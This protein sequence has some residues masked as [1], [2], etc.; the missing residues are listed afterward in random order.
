MFTL[1]FVLQI[2]VGALGLEWNALIDQLLLINSQ[3]SLYLYSKQYNSPSMMER[4]G[5]T[6]NPDGSLDKFEAQRTFEQ[7]REDI[8]DFFGIRPRNA[9]VEFTAPQGYGGTLRRI[10]EQRGHSHEVIDLMVRRASEGTEIGGCA[11]YAGDI[12]LDP[13]TNPQYVIFV[14]TAAK[15]AE[16]PAT[17]GEEVTHGEHLCEVISRENITYPQYLLKFHTISNE[18]LG[19][20][21]RKRILELLDQDGTYDTTLDASKPLT[22]NQWGHLFG[23]LVVDDLMEKQ[24]SLPAKDLFLAPDEATMW[25]ILQEAMGEPFVFGLNFAKGVN[26]DGLIQPLNDLIAE[27]KAENYIKLDFRQVE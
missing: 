8:A 5:I 10:L 21:G 24:K 17:L 12:A 6:Y 23:Y 25:K 26:F 18:F 14:S 16:F 27:N 2:E 15:I 7:V 3:V 4:Y 11:L 9:Y 19:Y 1:R 22:L 13:E 20:L